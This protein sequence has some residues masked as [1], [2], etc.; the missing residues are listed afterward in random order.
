MDKFLFTRN[1]T[2]VEL[3]IHRSDNKFLWQEGLSEDFYYEIKIFII[4]YSSL[5]KSRRT[6]VDLRMI[7]KILESLTKYAK[8][9]CL[10]SFHFLS[11][12]DL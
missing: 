9:H 2:G 1:N 10:L 12:S 5:Y 6:I 3:K 7:R 8:I 4:K 11:N